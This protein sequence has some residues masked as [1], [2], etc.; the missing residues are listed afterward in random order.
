MNLG[1]NNIMS[2]VYMNLET[3][4]R[5]QSTQLFMNLGTNNIMSTVYMNLETVT[6]ELSTQLFMNLGAQC[7]VVHIVHDQQ[8]LPVNIQYSVHTVHHTYC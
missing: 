4:T 7:S 2:T 6:R 5:E 1:T 8:S 3:V